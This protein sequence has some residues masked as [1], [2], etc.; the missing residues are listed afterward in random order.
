MKVVALVGMPGSGKSEVAGFFES[1]GYIRVR[2]GD[3]TD[4]E[5]RKRGLEL[6]E[7][8]ERR[9]RELLRQEH[10]MAAY[11]LLNL[12]R[13]DSAREQSNVVVDGLYSW[14][15][16]LLLKQYY[17]AAFMVIA[18]W[19]SPR[20]RYSRLARRARRPLNP[21][22]AVSRDHAEIERV[23][24]GGPIAMA[25]YT[26]LNESS[27]EDLKKQAERIISELNGQADQTR[28]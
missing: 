26:L 2:F 28:Y 22:E 13:I 20:T 19:S 9:V 5:V 23:N 25:D 17:D 27:L 12:P 8:N 16:Y 18:V 11:A 10:G 21:E 3:I 1:V 6:N 4:L 15:E 14:E 7:A 24:K